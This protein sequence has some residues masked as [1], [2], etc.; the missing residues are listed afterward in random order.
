MLAVR[1]RCTNRQAPSKASP[2][3]IAGGPDSSHGCTC[4]SLAEKP[5]GAFLSV[6]LSHGGLSLGLWLFGEHLW[7]SVLALENLMTCGLVE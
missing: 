1:G 4:L 7:G 6:F 5:G 3:L 2:K